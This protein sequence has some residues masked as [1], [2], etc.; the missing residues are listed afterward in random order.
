[1]TL[2]C[3]KCGKE[4]SNEAFY[5]PF[6]GTQIK[7]AISKKTGFPIAG[8]ILGIIASCICIFVGI[9]GILT[10]AQPYYPYSRFG[11]L[12]MGI[13]GL[14]GFAFGLTGGILTLRRKSFQLAIIG[15][16]LIL[17]SGFITI[18]ASTTE[19]YGYIG[20]VIFGIPVIILSIL[21]LIFTSISKSEFT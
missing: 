15:I 8:G 19:P 10:S 20:G 3:P 7:T 13:F 21:S 12:L 9:L 2:Y 5:C 18:L 6:C 11:M 17:V 1:M 4:V 16:S 14:I